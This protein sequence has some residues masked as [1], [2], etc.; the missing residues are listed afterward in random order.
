MKSYT[1]HSLGACGS[2]EARAAVRM[3]NKRWFHPTVNPDVIGPR[4]AELDYIQGLMRN[5]ECDYL[6]SN[7]FAF[8]GINTSL[9]FKRI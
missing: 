8:E 2:I 1:G 3:M 5:I 7:N 6:M 9:I 4:C